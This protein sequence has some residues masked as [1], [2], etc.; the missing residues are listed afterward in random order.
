MFITFANVIHLICNKT[1][2]T[3]VVT[4][5]TQP[6]IGMYHVSYTNPLKCEYD[7]DNDKR[8]LA[9]GLDGSCI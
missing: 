2:D 6:H 8:H 3:L 7:N 1:H 4:V 5:F 9:S